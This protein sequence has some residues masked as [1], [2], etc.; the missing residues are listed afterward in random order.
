M[1][2]NRINNTSLFVTVL[3]TCL[4]LLII[5][6]PP[7][8]YASARQP[9]NVVGKAASSQD[10][11]GQCDST[12]LEEIARD[13]FA[14]IGL[15]VMLVTDFISLLDSLTSGEDN[16]SGR[17]NMVILAERSKDGD[18]RL[19]SD[20]KSSQ[21]TLNRWSSRIPSMSEGIYRIVD[22]YSLG[23]NGVTNVQPSPV[24]FEFR[25]D[26]TE[27]YAGV[28]F[29]QGSVDRAQKYADAVNQRLAYTFCLATE[30][31][32]D[33]DYLLYRNARAVA[34]NS[35]VQIV[36]RLPRASIDALRESQSPAN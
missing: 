18:L 35:Q 8:M 19:S 4:G 25:L 28:S 21:K 2:I 3:S 6:V 33:L 23:I 10:G 27:F 15:D 24:R 12:R 30:G 32:V 17:F 1:H 13:K 16:L 29:D 9:L 26:E 7:Q 14:S 31:A 36:T 22:E 34:N 5:G 11:D 20:I